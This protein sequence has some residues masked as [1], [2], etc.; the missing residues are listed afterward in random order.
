MDLL[1][2]LRDLLPTTEKRTYR[3]V[4]FPDKCWDCYIDKLLYGETIWNG[5]TLE[6]YP[7]QD[8]VRVLRQ[9][10]ASSGLPT[11]FRSHKVE[12]S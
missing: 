3:H 10:P 2:E 11:S 9:P 7:V 5:V 6:H 4:K 1:K 12:G 8:V